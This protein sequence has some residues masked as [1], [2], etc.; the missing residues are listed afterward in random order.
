MPSFR[1]MILDE[2]GIVAV[3]SDLVQAYNFA[4]LTEEMAQ[5]AYVS[6]TIPG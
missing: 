5:I 6:S 3:G 4:D 1:V 2:H